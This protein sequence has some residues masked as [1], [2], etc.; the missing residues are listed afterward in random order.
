MLNGEQDRRK[1]TTFKSGNDNSSIP[2]ERS[3]FTIYQIGEPIEGEIILKFKESREFEHQGIRIELIGV[4]RY[5]QTTASK[6]FFNQSEDLL[7]PGIL[8][9]IVSRVPFKFGQGV[10]ASESNYGSFMYSSELEIKYFL[11]VT[12]GRL[13]ADIQHERALWVNTLPVNKEQNQCRKSLEIG[14]EN[15]IRMDF[16]IENTE[17]SMSTFIKGFLF[18]HL[19]NLPIVSAKLVLL[20]KICKLENEGVVVP[21]TQNIIK[22]QQIIDGIPIPNIEIPFSFS[23]LDCLMVGNFPAGGTINEIGKLWSVRYFFQ[24]VLIDSQHRHYFKQQEVDLH[25]SSADIAEM[26]KNFKYE[27]LVHALKSCS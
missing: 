25:F 21:L 20:Q 12:I 11:R 26:G 23:L 2:D 7:S 17:L 3:Q 24:L 1:Y 18:F 16:V 9:D 13:V 6:V 15:Y 8:N 19:I 22:S 5:P 27:N 14:I 10:P 4:I